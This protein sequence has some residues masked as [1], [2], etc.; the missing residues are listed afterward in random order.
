MDQSNDKKII[1]WS[2]EEFEY[3]EKS[4]DWFWAVGVV[5]VGFAVLSIFLGNLLFALLIII[6][7]FA[8][9]M[10]AVR[11]PKV[12]NFE[13]NDEGIIIDKKLYI[14]NTLE[15]FWVI[16]KEKII[17]KS[18]KAVVPF[19]IIPLQNMNPRSVREYLLKNLK[20]EEM[21]EPFGQ[22]V[23]EKLGF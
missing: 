14:Y 9:S 18:K 10:Q 4:V 12:I 17:I 13:I 2:A 5:S 22:V 20:E 21:S 19:L 6:S 11:K 3:S 15:S 1:R 16:N 23:M 7:A 8:L